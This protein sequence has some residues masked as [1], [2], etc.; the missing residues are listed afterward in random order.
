MEQVSFFLLFYRNYRKTLKSQTLFPLKRTLPQYLAAG[1]DKS[2]ND[3][4]IMVFDV[5]RDINS[6]QQ[7]FSLAE[8]QQSRIMPRGG[9][10][11]E[12]AQGETCHS[13]AWFHENPERLVAGMNQKNLKIYDLRMFDATNSGSTR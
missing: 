8:Q 12:I 10:T 11:L 5:S 3:P 6:Q 1:F 13:L 9:H 2:R 7:Q 4:A